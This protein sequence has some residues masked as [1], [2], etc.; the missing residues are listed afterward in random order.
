MCNDC[1]YG[2]VLGN[3]KKP[4]MTRMR[5]IV[6]IPTIHFKPSDE[7]H[8]VMAAVTQSMYNNPIKPPRTVFRAYVILR[9]MS[10]HVYNKHANEKGIAA[11]KK[12]SQ[13]A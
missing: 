11:T 9:S 8:C 5:S 4:R 6:D 3:M 13:G 12:P 10:S 7:G 1:D 2:A